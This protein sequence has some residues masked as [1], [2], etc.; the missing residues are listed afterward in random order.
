[1]EPSKFIERERTSLP[2]MVYAVYLYY[3]SR[4]LLEARFKMP[5]AL[6]EEES[7]RDMEVGPRSLT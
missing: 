2:L 3:S 1:M 6:C 5:R 7:R 4:S